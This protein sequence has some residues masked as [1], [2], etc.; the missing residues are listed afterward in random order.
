MAGSIKAIKDVNFQ[1]IST[2]LTMQK[3]LLFLAGIFLVANLSAQVSSTRIQKHIQILS[4]DSLEGRG[5]GTAGEK[6]AL[7]YIQSQWKEMGVLPRG[8]GK[9]YSQKFTFKSGVHGTG[10][11]G[12]A[13]NVVGYID[14]KAPNTVVIGAHYDH[15]GLG[16][17][18]SSLDANPQNKI[19]NGA[20]DNAS[21]VAGVLELARYFQT[22]KVKESTNFLFICFSGEELGL[23]GSKFFT[24]QPTI[25][26]DK[27]TYM[28]NMD[29]VG[30]LDPATKSL[31][32]SGTGTSPVWEPLLK[33]LSSDHLKIK[34]DS[35]GVGPSDHT[36]FYLKNIPVLHFFTGS[37]SDYH[38]PSDDVEKINVDGE[39][40]ILDLIIQ[41]TEKLNGQPKLA[42]LTTKNKSMSSARS[43]KVTMGVMPSYTSN[44]EGLKVDGV[45]EGK[46]AQKAGILTGDVIVQIGDYTIKDIQAYMDSL[47]KFEKGQ[48]VPVKVK[49]GGETVTVQ[50]TF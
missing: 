34:T 14:N 5:T 16:N 32:V 31:A 26:L 28:I 11:E 41:L 38:K 27:I 19:H 6:L 23:Y 7:H 47:T 15:L 30:R 12:T 25:P 50:V 43:F 44:E 17:Q 39:K 22:N 4:S 1:S 36:S 8:D 9:G 13:Y 3:S 29:M 21:G 40:E 2:D 10:A 33:S 48:T 42:F 46:P 24:E 35:A 37:H 45:S 20:D 18:G 49:R